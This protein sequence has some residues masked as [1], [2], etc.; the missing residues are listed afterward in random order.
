MPLECW[1]SPTG[2]RRWAVG[3]G[4]RDGT[5]LRQMIYRHSCCCS[6][7]DVFWI[8]GFDVI[9]ACRDVEHDRKE[10]KLFSWPSRRGIT[11]GLFMAKANH[12]LTI[13]DTGSSGANLSAQVAVLGGAGDRSWA[14]I[15]R[16]Q[17][18]ESG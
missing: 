14:A 4:A 2:W 12:V 18:R 6:H 13:T 16:E 11:N 15:L 7:D 5:F 3:C 8:S 9:Y 10:E 17:H 1:A